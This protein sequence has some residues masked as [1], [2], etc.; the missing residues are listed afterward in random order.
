[1]DCPDFFSAVA[2]KLKRVRG[3]KTDAQLAADLGLSPSA[4][5]NRKQS[6]AVPYVAICELCVREGISL[7]AV[8]DLDVDGW[9]AKSREER[10]LLEAYRRLEG[11]DRRAV[12][13][14]AAS[15]LSNP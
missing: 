8:L 12:L 4:Y 15:L 2:E 7:D 14:H 13:R 9:N 11:E 5:N 10:E 6:G 1:M 3:L